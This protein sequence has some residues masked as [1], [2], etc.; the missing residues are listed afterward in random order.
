MI[1]SSKRASRVVLTSSTVGSCIWVSGWRVAFSIA[2]QQVA[3]ARGDEGDRVAGAAGPAGAADAVHVG[4]GVGGDVVVDDVAD[5]LDVEPAGGDVGRDQDVELA[6]AQLA[7]GPLALRLRDVAVDGLA[8]Y[9]RAR[10]FSA[11]VSVSFLVRTKTISPSKFSTSRMRVRAST[12][13]G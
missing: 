2:L 4:L 1:A 12:F 9:P 3:L 5:P 6:V 7:D 8:E 11:S 13:C 10:S